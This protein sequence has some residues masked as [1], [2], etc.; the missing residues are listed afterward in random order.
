MKKLI[1]LFATL[2]L[3]ACGGGSDEP[4][5]KGSNSANQNSNALRVA[6]GAVTAVTEDATT[7]DCQRV[8]MRMEMPR[9]VGGSNNLFV[10]HTVF[11]YGVN[12]CME[13]NTSLKASRWTAYQ[14]YK[15]FSTN[16]KEDEGHA[17]F[18]RNYWNSTEW[19]GDPFQPDPL[20]PAA[21]RTTP[22]DHRNNGYDRG[23]IL[24]SADR[25]NSMDANE[26]T[27]YMSNI[28]P[29]RAGFNQQGIWYNLEDR[30]RKMYDLDSFRDTLYVV[31]GGTIAEGQ[32][33]MVRGSGNSLVCPEYFFMALLCKNANASLGGYKAIGFWMKH[34]DNTSADYKAY[35]VSIDELEKK[36]GIDFFCN[37]PDDIEQ[38]VEAAMSPKAW[39][40]N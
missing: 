33:T 22:N 40:I 25:L 20:I 26:Q 14:W 24:G 21:Y 19:E 27:F 3:T 30:L 8:A 23:H 34:E 15:G 7:T 39:K 36:T 18:N 31:K 32:Y 12:Y 13:Y 16:V 28:H 11:H 38:Q 35:A 9:L 5:P 1:F 37:L 6:G 2:A 4:A 10:V 29:Q 17:A